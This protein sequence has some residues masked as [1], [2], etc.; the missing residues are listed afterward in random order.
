MEPV[1]DPWPLSSHDIRPVSLHRTIRPRM[2]QV[3]DTQKETLPIAAARRRE[4][5]AKPPD[6][7]PR[8]SRRSAA[9]AAAIRMA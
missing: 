7:F 6:S 8:A 9:L 5:E 4:S 2:A 3:A 1:K